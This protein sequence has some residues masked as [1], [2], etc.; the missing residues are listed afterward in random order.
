MELKRVN[1]E[2]IN[3]YPKINEVNEKN[4][5]R[6]WKKFSLTAVLMSLIIKTTNIYGISNLEIMGDFVVE[7]PLEEGVIQVN[8]LWSFLK[9]GSK[10]LKIT[11]LF[12]IFISIILTV[13]KK[14]NKESKLTKKKLMFVYI[15]TGISVIVCI[16]LII[17]YKC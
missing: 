11:S 7:P 9:T 10:V 16:G 17:A 3:E 8:P 4:K 14:K 2:I 1:N 12:L 6:K 13:I 5:I 15:L